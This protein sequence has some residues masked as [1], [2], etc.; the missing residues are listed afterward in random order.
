MNQ[1]QEIHCHQHNI[2][3]TCH[4]QPNT[5]TELSELKKSKIKHNISAVNVVMIST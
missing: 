5:K 3:I 2:P 4:A 1:T